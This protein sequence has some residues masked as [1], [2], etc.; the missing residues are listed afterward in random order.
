MHIK[1]LPVYQDA[2][3]WIERQTD[4]TEMYSVTVSNNDKKKCKYTAHTKYQYNNYYILMLCWDISF[5]WKT[6][7]NEKQNWKIKKKNT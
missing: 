2:D 6:Q 1:F 5:I 3:R 4:I 7:K